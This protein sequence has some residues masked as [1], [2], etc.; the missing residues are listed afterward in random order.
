[1]DAVGAP[2]VGRR[3]DL[4]GVVAGQDHRTGVVGK[5]PAHRGAPILAKV[6]VELFE[7]QQWWFVQ[8][9]S[10]QQQPCPLGDP[11][12]KTISAAAGSR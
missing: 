1:V 11:L 5:E 3:D 2:Y 9:R 7:H 10:G 12:A 4:V 8:D 6:G